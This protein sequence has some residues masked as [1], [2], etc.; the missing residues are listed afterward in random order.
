MNTA[1][2]QMLVVTRPG[3]ANTPFL[4][5]PK[6]ESRKAVSVAE[7]KSQLDDMRA[8]FERNPVTQSSMEVG[9]VE[10]F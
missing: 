9:D 5:E 8:R 10:L 6:L 3:V 2:E 1:I 4:S 7:V